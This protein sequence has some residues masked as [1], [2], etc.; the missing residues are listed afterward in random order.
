MKF[1]FIRDLDEEERRKPRAERIPVS[2]MCAVLDVSA[3]RPP[4]AAATT[5][6][7]LGALVWTS[8]RR[9]RT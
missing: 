4:A 6:H 1:D 7:D 3:R 2:L 8:D 9:G 5:W